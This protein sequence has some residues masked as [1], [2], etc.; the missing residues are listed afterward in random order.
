M[1]SDLAQRF[2]ATLASCPSPC[3]PNEWCALQEVL[4][5]GRNPVPQW[6][7]RSGICRN[8]MPP[9]ARST[10]PCLSVAE[11]PCGATPAAGRQRRTNRQIENTSTPAKRRPLSDT[12][13]NPTGMVTRSSS[14]PFGCWQMRSDVNDPPI[15][16][17]W[18]PMTTSSPRA[19]NGRR[20]LQTSPR[21]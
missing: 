1:D 8:T 13:Y 16:K 3:G 14:S 6:R 21:T 11:P 19:R 17:P 18:A 5:K 12:S 15:L 4:I 10:A 2:N 9:S 7:S 20:V